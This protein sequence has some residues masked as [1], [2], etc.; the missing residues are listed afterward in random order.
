[1]LDRETERMVMNWTT[2]PS[3][4]LDAAAIAAKTRN[5]TAEQLLRAAREVRTTLLGLG[6]SAEYANERARMYEILAEKAR[7]EEDARAAQ[8][9]PSA[10]SGRRPRTAGEVYAEEIDMADLMDIE[11]MKAIVDKLQRQGIKPAPP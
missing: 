7:R 2:T 9:A 10:A 11:G 4:A 3:S 6:Q 5:F 8:G 1:M